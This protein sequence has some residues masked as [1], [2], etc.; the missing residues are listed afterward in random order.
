VRDRAYRIPPLSRPDAA[1]LV[2]E[3]LASPLLFGHL[4]APATDAAAM[5]DLL[6]RVGQLAYDLPEVAQLEMNPV[7]VQTSGLAV[8]AATAT[9]APPAQRRDGPARRLG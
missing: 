5:E 1:E 8:L 4:G 2:R 3:P 7:L 9:L 6:L